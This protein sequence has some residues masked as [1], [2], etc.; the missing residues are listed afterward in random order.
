VPR[1]PEE[2]LGDWERRV[3]QQTLLTAEL[4]Q[5]LEQNSASAESRD[6]EAAVTV[7]SS[8]GMTELRISERAMRLPA[9][10]LAAIILDTNR[11]AQ[12]KLARQT[13]DVVSGLYGADSQTAS[14]IG[15]AYTERFP[16][17]PDEEERD[18]R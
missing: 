16:E 4:A 18:R 1:D 8:G 10:E 15:G 11:R 17:P 5:Q 7:D 12:A 3:G 9:G 13:V 2:L 6:G 14:F